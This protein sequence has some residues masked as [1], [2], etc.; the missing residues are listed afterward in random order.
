M[1]AARRPTPADPMPASMPRDLAPS[2]VVRNLPP[3]LGPD[4]V[5]VLEG[6]SFMVSDVVGDVPPGS[7][8]GLVHDDTRFLNRWQLTVDGVNLL[9]LRAGPVDAY[10][11]AFFLTNAE[12]PGLPANSLG[13]RRQRFVGGGMHERIELQCFTREAVTVELRLA[14]GTD[15][16]DLFEIKEQVRDR[17]AQIERDHAMDGSLLVFGYRNG[18]FEARTEVR[19]D[20][21][22]DRV[23]GDDLI[24]NLRLEPCAHWSCE[25][26]IPLKHGP[27]EITPAHRHFGEVFDEQ[28]DDPAARWQRARPTL[29]TD[30]D[31]LGDIYQQSVADLVALRIDKRIAGEEVV[32]LAAGLPWYLTVFGRDTLITGYQTIGL[33]S[34]LARGALLV[35]ALHQ[36][37]AYDDFRDEEPGKIFHE[38]RSGEL[39]QIGHK[40]HNPYY[41]AADTTQLWLILLD[42]YWRWTGDDELVRRLSDNAYAALDWIDRYGDLDGDGYVEYATRSV[43][44]L[45]NHCWRDSWDG[46]QYANGV[47]PPLPIATCEIQ[48]YTYDAKLRL[49]ELADGP[50]GDPGLARRLRAEAGDLRE[51]FN[52]DFWLTDRGGYYALGL[53]GDKRPIDAMTSNMGHLLWSGIVPEERARTV[54]DQLMS[55]RFF[56]GWG[57]RTTATSEAGYNPIGYHMGTVWPHDNSL[58]A[59]GLARYGFRSEANRII[60]AMV[61][62]AKSSNFRLPEAFSGYDRSFGRVPVPYP[63]ACDPQAWASGA[64]L[65]FLRTMLGLEPRQGRLVVDAALPPELGRIALRQL[66]AFGQRWDVEATGTQSSVRLSH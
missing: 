4:A 14:V 26:S 5:A 46:V 27:Y 39:T 32:L 42:E 62:A 29:E 36:G 58:V 12:L 28:R 22:A 55:D 65:L 54:A 1:D 40:P 31:L 35:L 52:R 38:Y 2:E 30:F 48:G 66:G 50:L 53:D 60:M 18:A 15:F 9:A 51:R 57:V 23:D 8:G 44:G 61:E 43:Q 13:V 21:P 34:D 33:G 49:A 11:A 45:G 6:R 63:T 59:Y 16:A 64:P 37:K 25:I 3:E 24:W 41:G 20:P 7:I 17:R 19:A 10:S 56:S 47:I